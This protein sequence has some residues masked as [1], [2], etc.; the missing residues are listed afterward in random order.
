MC[1]CRR[2]GQVPRPSSAPRPGRA[3]SRPPPPLCPR[4]GAGPRSAPPP[5]ASRCRRDAAAAAQAQQRPQ[6]LLYPAG[7]FSPLPASSSRRP[8]APAQSRRRLRR[9]R[10]ALPPSLPAVRPAGS[11]SDLPRAPHEAM[12]AVNFGKI[13]IGIYVEIK[14]SDGERAGGGGRGHLPPP[15]PS[16]PPPLP[17]SRPGGAA[18]AGRGARAGPRAPG[19][20]V[21]AG[22]G[23][24]HAR[25]ALRLSG[26]HGRGRGGRAPGG[27]GVGSGRGSV[28]GERG[29]FGREGGG[30]SG[31]G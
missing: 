7:A 22:P 16:L 31:R 23:R 27:A 25:R 4:R 29:A 28:G 15:P 26:E 10:P 17:A 30:P 21:C 3:R 5:P 9:A 13:Q 1:G 24:G 20:I 14:R 19:P 12:A 18:R 6:R 8:V 11:A 2:Q